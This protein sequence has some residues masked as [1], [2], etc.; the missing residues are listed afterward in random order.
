MGADAIQ[1]LQFASDNTAGMCPEVMEAYVRANKD[2][3]ASYGDDALTERAAN[4]LRELFE[5]DC[6]VFFVFNGTAANALALASCCQ[7]YHSIICYEHAHILV[8]ECGAP[9]FFSN[10]AKVLGAPGVNGKLTPASIASIADKCV[11]IHYHKPRVV[12]LTQCTELSTVY[13]LKELAEIREATDRFKLMTH[14]D[15]ARFANSVA[16]LN[17]APKATTWEAGVKVLCFGGTK[18]GMGNTEAVIFFDRDLAF[19]FEYR[20]KQAGQLASKMRFHGA[21]WLAMLENGMWLKHAQH[22][23]RC[24]TQLASRLKTEANLTPAFPVETNGVFINLPKALEQGLR[25]RGWAFYDFAGG[26]ARL[27]CSWQTTEA[28][29]EALVKDVVDVQKGAG[30]NR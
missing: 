11:D 21:A 28:D 4:K 10:G 29:V 26:T 27:M 6:E 7:S 1:K 12:S 20:C 25:D 30:L 13:Q 23:N 16:S 3:L 15:G 17:V 18:M 5:T 22:A 9:E 2:S 19:E 8:S 24:A 14:M